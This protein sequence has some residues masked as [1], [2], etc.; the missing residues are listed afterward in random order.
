MKSKIN[1]NEPWQRTTKASPI[2]SR[3]TRSS[4]RLCSSMAEPLR[5]FRNGML[6]L[7]RLV[8]VSRC[9]FAN[10]FTDLA[11]AQL[12]SLLLRVV[13][14]LMM[15]AMQQIMTNFVRKDHNPISQTCLLPKARARASRKGRVKGKSNHEHLLTHAIVGRRGSRIPSLT[16][17]LRG[18]HHGG[19]PDAFLLVHSFIILTVLFF[20]NF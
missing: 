3:R 1:T 2:A 15:F 5:P 12:T 10:E 11:T 9:L 19:S 14:I 13:A 6:S 20:E 18:V 16:G 17:L 8:K 4:A 7:C